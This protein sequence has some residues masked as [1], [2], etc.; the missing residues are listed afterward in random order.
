MSWRGS[1]V[2]AA[3]NSIAASSPENNDDS[4][5]FE[6]PDEPADDDSSFEGI[7]SFT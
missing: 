2:K 5:Q 1:N 6:V 3:V 7:H 4:E